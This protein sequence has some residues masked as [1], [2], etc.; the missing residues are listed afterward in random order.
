MH[1]QYSI[2]LILAAIDDDHYDDSFLQRMQLL[3]GT[4]TTTAGTDVM[5]TGTWF[6]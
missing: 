2:C 6:F 4:R 3:P 5:E 1:E